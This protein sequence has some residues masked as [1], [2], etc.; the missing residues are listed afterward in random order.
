M[1]EKNNGLLNLLGNDIKNSHN[2]YYTK[3]MNHKMGI[4]LDMYFNVKSNDES[5][6]KVREFFSI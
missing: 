4:F 5:K 6:N 2:S 3:K 1:P